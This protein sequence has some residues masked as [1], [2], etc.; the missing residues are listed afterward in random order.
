MPITHLTLLVPE[1]LWPEPEDRDVL[2][3]LDCPALTTL[4]VRSRPARRPPQ[5]PEATLADLFG[6]TENVPYGAFR[7][8][9]ERDMPAATQA[10]SWIA[11]DPVHLRFHQER[12]ILA[13]G[14]T[15]GI[16]AD[17]AEVLAGEMNR[18]FGDIGR[19]HVAAPERWYLELSG[20]SVLAGFIPPPLSTV[21][22]RS[23]ERLLPEI[24]Q[25]RAVR[26][27]LNEIQTFLHAHPVNQQREAKGLLPINSLWLWGAGSLPPRIES[28]F[29]GVWST[30]P[31]AIGLARAASVP[32]HPAPVDAATLFARAA[33]G[34]RQLVEL[35]DLAGPVQ[36]ENGEAYRH[37][38]ASLEHRWF[39]PLQ[40][41]LAAGRIKQL[42]IE[43]A[44]AYATLTW[45]SGRND[46]WKIWRRPQPLIEIAQRLAN[47]P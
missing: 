8:L 40:E 34:T 17:E 16:T 43:A 3:G 11:A 2:D 45:E 23:I 35:D 1:L 6:H 5:S 44:T 38:I 20:E 22:G 12:L 42:R 15:L 4:L 24:M 30:H 10:T 7:R 33:P 14:A 47:S 21:T 18:H 13:G 9:G 26:G 29:D 28:D 32:T 27:L 46:Q 19:A 37:A 41:A 31:L 36:Y 25:D 39:A